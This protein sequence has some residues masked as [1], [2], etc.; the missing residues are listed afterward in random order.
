MSISYN[1]SIITNGL[2]LCLDASNPRSYSGSGTTWSDAVSQATDVTLT[3]GPTYNSTNPANFSFDGVNDYANFAVSNLGTTTT[4]E[5]WVKLGS[6]YSGK[7]FFGWLYYDVWCSNGNI[8]FNTA[9]GDQYGMSSSVVTSLNCVGNWK[10]YIFEMRSDVSY[11]NNKIYINAIQQPLSQL[12]GT[13]QASQRNF[14]SGQ[15]RIACWRGDLDYAMPMNLSI[16][17]VY[18]TALTAAQIAKNFSALRGRF[19]V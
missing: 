4:V 12:A 5:M 14:N 2:V 16:F 9:G 8:G 3:N 17:R 18:N 1:P 10:Q 7:M 13:E 11:T 19:G 6:G 15:G